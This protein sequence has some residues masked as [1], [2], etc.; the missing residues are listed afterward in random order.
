MRQQ[1]NLTIH[2]MAFVALASLILVLLTLV[3]SSNPAYGHRVYQGADYTNTYSGDHGL[4]TCDRERDGYRTRGE[5][6]SFNTYLGGGVDKRANDGICAEG[7]SRYLIT[8]HRTCELDA[9][10][11]EC[12]RYLSEP[13]G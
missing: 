9:W 4:R 2:T 12:T 5:A 13:R 3:S 1:N 8:S 10:L 11:P 7:T 6:Y